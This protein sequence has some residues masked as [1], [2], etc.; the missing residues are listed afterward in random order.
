MLTYDD[1]RGTV[2]SHCERIVRIEAPV[3][4]VDEYS[5]DEDALWDDPMKQCHRCCERHTL[6]EWH[7]DEVR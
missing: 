6:S 3:T 5:D 4:I 2:S 1:S 7:R